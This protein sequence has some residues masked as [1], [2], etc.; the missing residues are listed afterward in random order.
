MSGG[1]TQRS[2]GARTRWPLSLTLVEGHL[3][4]VLPRRA[5]ALA[6]DHVERLGAREG[7]RGVGEKIKSQAGLG[8][9]WGWEHSFH[10][11]TRPSIHQSIHLSTPS[12]IQPSTYPHA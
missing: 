2:T 5:H 6:P 8:W 7:G 1:V 3:Q 11:F 10:L 9:G 4:A 12:N